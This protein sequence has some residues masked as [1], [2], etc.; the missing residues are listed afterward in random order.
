[1][2]VKL[3][4][5]I[6]HRSLGGGGENKRKFQQV[7]LCLPTNNNGSVFSLLKRFMTVYNNNLPPPKLA[8]SI[9]TIELFAQRLL[10]VNTFQQI[11]PCFSS[12]GK[13]MIL[14]SRTAIQ[15][16]A[17]PNFKPNFLYGFRGIH[18]T[19]LHFWFP[20]RWK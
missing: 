2:T 11:I 6:G 18:K 4:V 9:E 12:L 8:V 1:M 16:F 17:N 14:E 13:T 19:S 10:I 7:F 20:I 5:Q 15:M 3:W